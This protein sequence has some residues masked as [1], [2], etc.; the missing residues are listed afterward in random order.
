MISST[1]SIKNIEEGKWKRRDIVSVTV[2][3]VHLN[4]QLVFMD[5]T[6]IRVNGDTSKLWRRRGK[7]GRHSKNMDKGLFCCDCHQH[8]SNSSIYDF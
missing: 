6:Y 4:K 7:R 2:E 5:Q 8:N 1:Y 3:L